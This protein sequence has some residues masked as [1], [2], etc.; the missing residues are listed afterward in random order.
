MTKKPISIIDEDSPLG[1]EMVK[2]FSYLVRYFEASDLPNNHRLLLLFHAW[3]INYT[4]Y[5]LPKQDEDVVN[6]TRE[7]IAGYRLVNSPNSHPEHVN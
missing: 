5:G 2:F 6:L 3:L 4:S 1:Q 7:L